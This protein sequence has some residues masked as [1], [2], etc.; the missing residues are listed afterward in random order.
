MSISDSLIPDWWNQIGKKLLQPGDID[1]LV[2]WQEVTNANAWWIIE[3][4]EAARDD[5]V[6]AAQIY[7][8]ED[9]AR[10]EADKIKEQRNRILLHEK[11]VPIPVDIK[12]NLISTTPFE[13]K[14]EYDL[15]AIPG[16]MVRI[17]SILSDDERRQTWRFVKVTHQE[18]GVSWDMPLHI[19]EV[20]ADDT[21]IIDWEIIH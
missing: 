13:L 12:P 18:T 11:V 6:L 16:D 9:I 3:I 14:E 7:S 1:A 4:L 5:P 19:F 20:Y 2:L 15:L 10:Q 21:Q 8:P 17:D